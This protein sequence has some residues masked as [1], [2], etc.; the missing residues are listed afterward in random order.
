MSDGPS[1]LAGATDALLEHFPEALIALAI[2]Y[3]RGDDSRGFEV[4]V[5]AGTPEEAARLQAH[6]PVV[7][8]A[9]A[10]SL[11]RSLAADGPR[12]AYRVRPDPAGER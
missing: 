2:V 5:R 6:V 11:E 9:L 10:D 7:L 4:G 12:D 3:G 1:K 8:R